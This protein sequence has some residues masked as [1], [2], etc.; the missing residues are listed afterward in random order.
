MDTRLVTKNFRLKQWAEII[1]QCHDSGMQVK[2]WCAQ[3]QISRNSYFYW[4]RKL[5]EAACESTGAEFVK[6]EL[7]AAQPETVTF[8]PELTIQSGNYSI[9]ISSATPRELLCMV[10]EVASNAQ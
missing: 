8:H 9:G 2:D 6:V 10:L 3:N 4:Q 5:R 7:P 1:H